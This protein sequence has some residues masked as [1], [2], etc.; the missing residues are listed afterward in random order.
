MMI[1]TLIWALFFKGIIA[2]SEATYQLI[3]VTFLLLLKALLAIS[4]DYK[5][6]FRCTRFFS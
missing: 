2:L 6:M 3:H 5:N 1:P 4:Y